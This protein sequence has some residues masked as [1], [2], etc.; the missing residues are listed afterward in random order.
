MQT[1]RCSVNFFHLMIL[2]LHFRLLLLHTRPPLLHR[3]L[4]RLHKPL[5]HHVT[6]LLQHGACGGQGVAHSV[7]L[8]CLEAE[9][10]D[11][12]AGVWDAVADEICGGL[13]GEYVA[14]CVTERVVLT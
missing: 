2:L 8:F 10:D 6:Q 12:F 7:V 5:L 13:S 9:V 14:D 4:H 3:P 11:V 1:G